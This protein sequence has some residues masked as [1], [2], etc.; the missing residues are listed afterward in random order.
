MTTSK[1]RIRHPRTPRSRLFRRSFIKTATGAPIL[2]LLLLISLSLAIPPS[3]PAVP[4]MKPNILVILTDDQG[5]GD[6]RCHGNDRIDTPILDQLSEESARFERFFVSPLC[7]PSRASLLTG[8]YH[9]RTGVA[10]VTRGLETMRASE[11]TIAEALKPAGYATGCFGK[12]H[13][14]EHFPNH[15]NGQGFDEFFGLPTG[16]WDDYFDPELDHNG[17]LAPTRGYITDVLTDAA[18]GFMR[19]HRDGPFFC[20]VPFNAPHTPLQPPEAE[21]DKYKKRGFEDRTAA[22]Y[23]MVDNIDRNVGRLLNCLAELGLEE[24]TLVI[25]LSDNGAEGPEGS[26][27]NAGMRG[28]KG[29][30]HEGGSRVPCFFRWPKRIPAGKIVHPIAAHIDLFPTI[31]D[32]CGVPRPE[33]PP[34]DGCS[35]VPLLEGEPEEWPDRLLFTRMP[36]WKTL[37][38]YTAPMIDNP[39]PFP[40]AV[41]TGR[42]R[43]VNAGDGWQLFDMIRDPA[44]VTDVAGQ[45]PGEVS[46]LSAAYEE[47]FADVTRIPI[48][49]PPIP[50][51]YP[52][53]PAVVLPAPEAYFD[54]AIRWFRNWGFA[55]DWLTDWTDAEDAIRWEIDVVNAG[56]YEVVLRYAAPETSVGTG[57][58]V[59]AGNSATAG[60][61]ERAM[62]SHPFLRPARPA[63][64]WYL[65]EFASQPL[66]TLFLEPGRQ[67]LTL[68]AVT[69]V[70]AG[71]CEVESIRLRRVD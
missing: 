34:L 33:G 57:L 40:G 17:A 48:G 70:V 65:Q 53:H 37:V 20:F 45:Y 29:T 3:S 12:W 31:L 68:R 49:R 47:W 27:F 55:R 71:I 23:G 16:H 5:Y 54:G 9:L 18:A 66:G 28:M 21:F 39:E 59:E 19:D 69:K 36:G 4:A 52:D 26:R 43:L 10:S 63:D 14:G 7:S 22:I 15:P 60:I 25:F 44:Q 35:L 1:G 58:R 2:L 64:K 67:H 30:V 38:S 61:I 56:R 8:R 46:R 50:V 13:L 24:R 41:R 6:L 51:G 32:F 42:W 11:V 62:P